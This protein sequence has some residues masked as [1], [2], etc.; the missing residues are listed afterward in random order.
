MTTLNNVVVVTVVLA[1]G[2]FPPIEHWETFYCLNT[3]PRYLLS[4]KQLWCQFLC[5]KLKTLRFH[6]ILEIVYFLPN[7]R[8]RNVVKFI[9][10]FLLQQLVTTISTCFSSFRFS[11]S[12]NIVSFRNFLWH[13]WEHAI[14][15]QTFSI[16]VP[17][18]CNT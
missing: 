6:Y 10:A 9:H 5:F 17:W 3:S 16:F 4:Y 14:G 7:G 8:S 18:K 1:K 13:F 15:R 2:A 11:T 12:R